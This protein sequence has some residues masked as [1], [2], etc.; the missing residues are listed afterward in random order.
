MKI[1]KQTELVKQ[2]DKPNDISHDKELS[3]QIDTDFNKHNIN[4]L[5]NSN[6]KS[7]DKSFEKSLEKEINN[8][9]TKNSNKIDNEEHRDNI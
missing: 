1:A 8:Q 2:T 4:E 3:N 7:V 5:N 6:N 9:I